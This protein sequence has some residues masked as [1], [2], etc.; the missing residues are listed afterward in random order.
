MKKLLYLSILFL[1]FS[2]QSKEKMPVISFNDTIYKFGK[3][4]KGDS[5]IHTFEFTNTGN[6]PLIISDINS[7]CNCTEADYTHD[8]IYPSK[9]GYVK[10]K[11]VSNLKK[12]NDSIR[13]FIILKCNTNP[14]LKTLII[15]GKIEK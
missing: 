13:Q 15:T 5:I 10:V 4:N 3:I 12:R 8:S 1:L 6:A 7:S 11:F 9:K 2:C 14:I